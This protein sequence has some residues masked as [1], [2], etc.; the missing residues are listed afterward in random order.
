MEEL[1]QLSIALATLMQ[2]AYPQLLG[3]M[4]YI[5][6]LGTEEFFLITLP[7]VYWCVNKRLGRQIGYFFL[8]SALINNILK[9]LLRQPRPFWLAPAIQRGEAEGFGLPSGH[10]QNV[11]A[12]VLILAA[13]VRRGWFWLLGLFFIFLMALSRLY[14]GVHSLQD[15]VVGFI[16]GLLLFLVFI[17]WQQS[18]YDRYGKQILG[19]RLLIMIL[20]PTFLAAVYIGL[21]FLIGPA[22]TDVAWAE[23]IPAAELNGY[24]DIVSSLAG[25][26]GF[27]IG[28]L[29]ESSRIRF[30]VEGPIWKRVI[31][32]IL[33]M[34]V[35]LGIWAGLRA[36]FPAEPLWLA[37]P[38][39]FLRY[40]LLLFWVTYF[41]PWVFVKLRLA[42]ANPESE[43]QI[44][45]S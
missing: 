9:N 38:F 10:V 20:I 19:R 23:Y 12:V 7:A 31:R 4:T 22:N 24:E 43:V 26:F 36:V 40:L 17:V 5:S 33:G 34:T 28:I 11:T 13:H 18:M 2:E 45:F 37:L 32:Y 29:L 44:T 8:A 25:L 15:I 35:A 27:G 14:L 30:M 21:F 3:F 16:I 41:A 1:N 42:E 39:R 6:A